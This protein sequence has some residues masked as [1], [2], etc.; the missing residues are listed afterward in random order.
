LFEICFRFTSPYIIFFALPS[1]V[2]L[3]FAKVKVEALPC[4]TVALM[5]FELAE[6]LVLLRCP[7][8]SQSYAWLKCFRCIH[9]HKR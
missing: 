2:L 4:V 8:T 7:A 1:A 9:K 5:P 6:R 3:V